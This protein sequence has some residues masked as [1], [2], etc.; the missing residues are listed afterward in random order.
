ML[1]LV[2]H[3]HLVKLLG[4]CA[5]G[6]KRLLVYEFLP[7]YS[8]DRYLFALDPSQPILDWHTRLK[9]ALGSARG[10]AHLHEEISPPVSALP[11]LG[12]STSFLVCYG[13][14]PCAKGRPQ[15]PGAH[16]YEEAT[17]PMRD[18]GGGTS[19]PAPCCRRT[20]GR[21]CWVHPAQCGMAH[22]GCL[23]R[24]RT[25]CV[26]GVLRLVAASPDYLSRFQDVQHSAG[27]GLQPQ[28]LGLWPGQ[29][30]AQP[31][32]HA[33]VHSG[34]QSTGTRDRSSTGLVK[35]GL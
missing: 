5:E 12:S 7:Y 20:S 11:Q 6:E 13:Q 8:L 18:R 32:P 29:R 1:G 34:E 27:R 14:T 9:I 16:L 26:R 21:P 4:F 19:T 30:G 10:L 25:T 35:L 33:R 2:D 24:N 17:L 22:H 28:A 15:R 31:G 3:A 23:K